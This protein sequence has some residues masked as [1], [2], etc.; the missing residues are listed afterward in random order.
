MKTFS[1]SLFAFVCLFVLASSLRAQDVYAAIN[2]TRIQ[3]GAGYLYLRND[4]YDRPNGGLT[5]WADYDFSR[6]LGAEVE[7][8]FGGIVSPDDI[9]ENSYLLGPRLSY[10]RKHFTLYGKILVG[11]GSISNQNFH[12]S[13]S[14]DI[15][16][17]G[18]GLEYKVT[19]RINL[20][21]FDIEEQTWPH[22]FPH[23]LSPIAV[24]VG[25]MYVIR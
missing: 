12:I 23:P 24:S 1:V 2:N 21:A 13:S 20:R 9:G 14:Y 22:F 11:R 19:R 17:Y 16:A 25:A 15:Y 6:F 7:V 5:A 4:Y 8:H 10:R 3:A 18:G